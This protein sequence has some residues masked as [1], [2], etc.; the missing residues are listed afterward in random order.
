VDLERFPNER[1]DGPTNPHLF[2]VAQM[3][4]ETTMPSRLFGSTLPRC[5]KS[6]F[7]MMEG[8]T[9]NEVFGA[10]T[11]ANALTKWE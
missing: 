3:A 2:G 6:L 11:H 5:A 4:M 9:K 10:D 8:K 1:D 7:P